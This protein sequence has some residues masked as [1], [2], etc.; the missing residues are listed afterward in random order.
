MPF[1]EHSFHYMS[2]MLFSKDMG[3]AVIGGLLAAFVIFISSTVFRLRFPNFADILFWKKFCDGMVIIVSEAQVEFDP[4]LRASPSNSV[5]LRSEVA[6][7][8][9]LLNFIRAHFHKEREV[10]GGSTY[11]DKLKDKNLFIIG[12]PKYNEAAWRF[13]TEIKDELLYVPRRLLPGAEKLNEQE[14][15]VFVGRDTKYP[16]L[17]C[18]FEHEIQPVMIVLRKDLYAEK[19]WVLLVAGLQQ[20]GSLAGIEWLTTRPASFWWCAI[21]TQKGF[22]A[23]LQFRV[24]NQYK[25]SNIKEV[26]HQAL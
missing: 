23:M 6:A 9:N 19:K 17:T 14:M 7:T 26:F 25:V 15:K 3:V 4:Q 2:E 21:R 24:I 16:N 10:E 1:I 20:E 18:D 5:F 13:L 12:G 22:Q 11:F 8:N